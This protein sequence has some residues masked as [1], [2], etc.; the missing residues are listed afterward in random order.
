MKS[1]VLERLD[2]ITTQIKEAHENNE[3]IGKAVSLAKKIP[4]TAKK[5]LNVKSNNAVALKSTL[6]KQ[7]GL[8]E[9]AGR[10]GF[11]P[12]QLYLSFHLTHFLK[13]YN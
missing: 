3:V 9:K 4:T 10:L 11:L 12:Q 6:L 1:F 2:A 7:T 13:L 8:N 5:P